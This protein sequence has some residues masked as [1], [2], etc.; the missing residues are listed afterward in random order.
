MNQNPHKGLTANQGCLIVGTLT[1]ISGWVWYLWPRP[2][3]QL[4]NHPQAFDP[5]FWGLVVIACVTGGCVLTASILSWKAARANVLPSKA[6]TNEHQPRALAG[7]PV[8]NAAQGGSGADVQF[9]VLRG[10]AG[11]SP[12]Y[13]HLG[14][15]HVEL[16]LRTQLINRENLAITF[17]SSEWYAKLT[18]GDGQPF[19]IGEGAVLG[20]GMTYQEVSRYH[21]ESGLNSGSFDKDLIADTSRLPMTKDIPTEGWL[22]FVFRTIRLEHIFGC[23]IEVCARDDLDRVTTFPPKRPGDW[24]MPAKI[25]CA[26]PAERG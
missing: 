26:S 21:G 10:I 15:A 12:Q 25:W 3:V 1:F 17:R 20:G 9:R 11:R 19:E 6:E 16:I 13:G 22:R 8:G 4:Q 23:T 24:L 5:R 7:I 2:V 14:I 18:D